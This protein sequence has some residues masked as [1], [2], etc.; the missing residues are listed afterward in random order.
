MEQGFQQND[1]SFGRCHLVLS[2]NLSFI[3]R[4]LVDAF[5]LVQNAMAAFWRCAIAL[6]LLRPA[7]GTST[8]D[9]LRL[10]FR[11]FV[12]RRVTSLHG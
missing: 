1:P 6:Y 4:W 7:N 12:V 5:A 10:R 2:L 8:R 11:L 3:G 9:V